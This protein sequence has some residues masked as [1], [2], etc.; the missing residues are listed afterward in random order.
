MR[1]LIVSAL[2][3]TAAFAELPAQVSARMFRY[4][5]VSATHIAFAYAGDV[6]VVPK[7]G[8]V[9]QRLSSPRGEESFPRFSPDGTKLAYSAAYDGNQEVY[10]IPAMGGEPVRV[11]YH[12]MAD[13]V[14]DWYPDG[15][16]LL[17]ATSMASGR[18]RYSQFFRVSATG[19]LP[20]RL[21]VPYGEFGAISPDGRTLAYMPMSQDFRTWKRYRGGWSADIWTFD[22]TT[23]ASENV[24][25]NPGNDAHPMWHGRTM[26]FLSDRD[27]SQRNNI[28][29]YELDSRRTRQVT[30]F[31]DFDIT[32]PAIGP[33]D[34]VFEAGGRLYLLDLATEQTREVGV[35]VVTDLAT[36]RPRPERVNELIMSFAV[37]PSGQRA[38]FEARGDVFS[39]PQRFGPVINLTRNSGSA[40]R[41][42]TWSPDGRWVAYWSDRWGEYE[43]TVRAG[44]GTGEERRVSSYGPGFRYRPHW[45]PDSRKVAFVD[46]TMTIRIADVASGQTTRVD[47]ALYWYQGAL[48]S[49][50]PSWSADSRWLAYHRDLPN[51]R[52]AIFLHDTRTGRSQQVTSGFYNDYAPVFDPEGK[53]LY[54]YSDRTLRPVYSDVDNTWVYPNATNIVAVSL[55]RDVP[56]PL[57]PRNDVEAGDTATR[58]ADTSQA[59]PRGR[60]TRGQPATRRPAQPP[61]DT[62]AGERAPAPVEIDTAGFEQRLTVLPPVA[63]NFGELAAIAG[64]VLFRRLPVSGSTDTITPVVYYDLKEREE[65]TVIADADQ[66]EVTHDGKRMLV[67]DAR[68]YGIIEIK[69]DQRIQHPLRVSEMEAVVDPRAEWRQIFTDVWRFQRD[70]FYDPNLHGVDWN[71]M[72]ERYGRLLQDA[73]TRWDVNFVI[74]EFISELNASHTYRGGGDL[75]APPSRPIGLLGVDWSLEGGAYRIARIVNGAPWDTEVR[76]PLSRPGVN[77]GV[78]DYLLAVNGVPVDTSRAPWAA[79]AG[80]AGVSVE[81]TVNDRP[82]MEGARRVVVETLTD[83]TRLRHLEWIESNRRRVVEASGGRVGYIYVP[84]TGIDGQTELLRQFAHQFTREALIIDERFNSGG[85]IPDRF[86]ELLNRP[87]LVYW[88]VRHGRDWQWP[89]FA[90]FGPKVMLINGWSGSGGDAFPNYFRESRLGPLIGLRTWGGL[91]GLTGSPPLVDGGSVTVPTF[92]QYSTRGEWFAEG[93]GVD[94]DIEVVDDPT[95]MARGRDPQLERAIQETLRLLQERPF[96]P[97]RRPAYEN[98]TPRP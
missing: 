34:I 2:L 80:L 5:D 23:L 93:H 68:R 72:R 7:S 41:T 98:R 30:R 1:G 55:R 48:Q 81:L 17:V 58:R 95:E 46:E 6:W 73:V 83:E 64:K 21:S 44:D 54:F 66:F 87:P 89:P 85:Q 4:P 40:E 84:S 51:R 26:Y 61:A 25:R 37:S 22:L 24:T 59:A 67:R 13:R 69:P 38:L 18:Q 62:A 12:P 79:F 14:V 94:P 29:A 57:A 31:T 15:R 20:V 33:S 70:F 71:A 42:P 92:R 65:K 63:G 53:Y 3:A 96:V 45:S 76:S 86:I 43:L 90:H 56:S 35:S 8:G 88:G 60:P 16:S 39:V 47:R 11:T 9:A 49:F 74:G 91:I 32:F 28:W 52:N 27:P 19:G 36:L 75:E 77:V 10:V 82:T 50:R 78:G 97:P